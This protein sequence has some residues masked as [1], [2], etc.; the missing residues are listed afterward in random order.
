MEIQPRK[1]S[2][3]NSRGLRKAIFVIEVS[4]LGSFL[5]SDGHDTPVFRLVQVLPCAP[6][7]MS[8]LFFPASTVAQM[9]PAKACD[10]LEQRALHL[11]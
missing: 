9:N 7:Q 8:L 4:D 3:S 5:G 11:D 10:R 2:Y 1:P 6:L